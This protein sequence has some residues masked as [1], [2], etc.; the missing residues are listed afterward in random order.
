MDRARENHCRT[1]ITV[2][3]FFNSATLYLD[4]RVRQDLLFQ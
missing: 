4:P 3:L 1:D 2:V